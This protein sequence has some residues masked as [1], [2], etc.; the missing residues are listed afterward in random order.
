MRNYWALQIAIILTCTVIAVVILDNMGKERVKTEVI[1]KKMTLCRS[2]G[3]LTED[4]LKDQWHKYPQQTYDD[5]RTTVVSEC[6]K[7]EMIR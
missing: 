2:L 5:I 7:L 1:S 4:K 3:S 6:L